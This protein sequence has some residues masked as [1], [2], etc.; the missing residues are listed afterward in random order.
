MKDQS[1][2]EQF[3]LSAAYCLSNP[4]TFEVLNDSGR[5][6]TYQMRYLSHRYL[7]VDWAEVANEFH[8][9]Y[10]IWLK[11]LGTVQIS[12]EDFE[13]WATAESETME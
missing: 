1:E 2:F 3:A 11:D 5:P 13:S 4:R 6:V 12:H 8:P 10:A 7:E 9:P